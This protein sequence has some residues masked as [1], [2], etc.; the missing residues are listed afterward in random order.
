MEGATVRAE[1]G[2]DLGKGA[3]VF[4]VERR[5]GRVR[6]DEARLAAR[7]PAVA[8]RRT[9]T[10]TVGSRRG[11]IAAT[12]GRAAAREEAVPDCARGCA[13]WKRGVRGFGLGSGSWCGSA[14]VGRSAR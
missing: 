2:G 3:H 9:H 5:H 7:A 13:I 14:G 1:T 12:A 6:N 10:R 8:W 4:G 11:P